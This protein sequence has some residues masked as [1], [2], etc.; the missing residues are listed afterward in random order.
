MAE[1]ALDRKLEMAARRRA[2]VGFVHDG[3]A[4]AGL[5]PLPD[6]VDSIT[7]SMTGIHEQVTGLEVPVPRSVDPSRDKDSA[8]E[9]GRQAYLSWAVGRALA[10]DDASLDSIVRDTKSLGSAEEIAALAKIVK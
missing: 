9:A 5:T 10:Q 2:Q 1:A 7:R 4:D 3:I 8:W 6:Q